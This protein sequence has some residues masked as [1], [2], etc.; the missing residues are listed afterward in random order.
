MDPVACVAAT[1]GLVLPPA[2]E[3]L[4]TVDGETR[5]QGRCAVTRG[6]S[7]LA[8]MALWLGGFPQAAPHLPVTLLIQPGPDGG[9]TWRRD[10]GGHVTQSRLSV[11]GD[12]R[13]VVERFGPIRLRMSLRMADGRLHYGIDQM[14]VLGLPMPRWLTPRSE[15][16]EYQTEA[17]DFGF[18]VSASLPFAGLLIR[19]H[20]QLRR[21]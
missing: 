10:F 14:H 12:G 9:C 1:T 2:I 7:W 19:Y 8:R 20:G 18:D 4:H 5:F 13:E 16:C 3:A 17:G 21:A 6:P 11:S 15:T